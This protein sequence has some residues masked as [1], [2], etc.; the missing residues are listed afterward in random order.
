MNFAEPEPKPERYFKRLD[1]LLQTQPRFDD[2]KNEEMETFLI[3]LAYY[4]S[5]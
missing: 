3:S 5:T 2:K 4:R 1:A